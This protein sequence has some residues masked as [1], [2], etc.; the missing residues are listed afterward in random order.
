[1]GPLE[2]L[3]HL[4]GIGTPP[5][6]QGAFDFSVGL[7]DSITHIES[8]TFPFLN[9]GGCELQFVYGSYGR[10]KSHFL[11]TVEQAAKKNG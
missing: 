7:E 8:E 10:G 11:H 3:A 2:V 4:A 1:M 6:A 9:V 5:A